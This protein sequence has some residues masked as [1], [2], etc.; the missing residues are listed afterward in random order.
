MGL[1]AGTQIVRI[2]QG[3]WDGQSIYKT[4]SKRTTRRSKNAKDLAEQE[5]NDEVQ[6]T[7]GDQINTYIPYRKFGRKPIFSI[8]DHWKIT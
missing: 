5:T 4:Q 1:E 6:K 2:F 3:S 7:R 8:Y